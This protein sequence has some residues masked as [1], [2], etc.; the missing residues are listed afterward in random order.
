MKTKIFIIFIILF[1]SIKIFSQ[2]SS[3][4]FNVVGL[5]DG[6]RDSKQKDREE[7]IIN[8]KL[9]A[10]EKAGI[11]IKSVT[12]FENFVLK[13]DW[14]ETK[15]EAYIEPG[16]TILDM[17][18]GEDEVYRVV[19]IGKV[20]RSQSSQK[21]V[22]LTINIT[23]IL[24]SDYGKFGNVDYKIMLD[25]DLIKNVIGG[26]STVKVENIFEGE[27]FLTLVFGSKVVWIEPK[28][29]FNFSDSI[30]QKIITKV[31]QSNLI[32]FS[33]KIYWSVNEKEKLKKMVLGS[34]MPDKNNIFDYNFIDTSGNKHLVKIHHYAS[35]KKS[36]FGSSY[37]WFIKIYVNNSLVQHFNNDKNTT[38]PK[39]LF[40][41]D[42]LIIQRSDENILA[43]LLI[44][45]DI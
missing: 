35:K 12:T 17:G 32:S 44:R 27:H 42:V 7:A 15:A 43:V 39:I 22:D 28:Y 5:S 34:L 10:I 9:L 19:L 37:K 14:I 31:G 2:E 36:L 20:K 26:A 21:L 23:P 1:L 24:G 6:K 16:F 30:R 38:Y 3:I 11:N 33:P 40:E 13:K 29:K 8:A 4:D 45:K 41:N 25:G 18:Y